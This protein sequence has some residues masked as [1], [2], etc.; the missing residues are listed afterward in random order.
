[1]DSKN[2]FKR[3]KKLNYKTERIKNNIQ[4]NFFLYVFVGSLTRK[5]NTTKN[6]A[7]IQ[8][9]KAQKVKIKTILSKN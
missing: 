9:T 4:N 2:A 5:L 1:M 3:S 6:E 7:N 8:K